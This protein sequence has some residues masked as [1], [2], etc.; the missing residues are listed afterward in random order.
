M[1][2]PPNENPAGEWNTYEIICRGDTVQSY[3]NGKLMNEATGC[4]VSS[5]AIA[6]QSEGGE[7]E[8][9]KAFIEP[10]KAP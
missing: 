3:V 7:W 9:R 4:S 5:G 1:Q 6:I 8:L 10:L 2:Q